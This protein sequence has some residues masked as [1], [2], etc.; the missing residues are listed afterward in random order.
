DYPICVQAPT[1]TVAATFWR[2]C[3]EVIDVLAADPLQLAEKSGQGE[4]DAWNRSYVR[5]CFVRSSDIC[6]GRRNACTKRGLGGSAVIQ[7]AAHYAWH[8]SRAVAAQGSCSILER[9]D[10]QWNALPH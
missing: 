4:L 9:P 3:R 5:D 8:H 7:R 10:R 6:A 2:H 1:S